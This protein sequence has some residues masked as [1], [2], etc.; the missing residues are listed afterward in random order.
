[1]ARNTIQTWQKI[2]NSSLQL[3][4]WLRTK[5][6]KTCS[7]PTAHIAAKMAATAYSTARSSQAT[8]VF[9]LRRFPDLLEQL[10]GAEFLRQLVLR[11]ERGLHQRPGVDLVHF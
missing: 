5:R 7:R 8:G 10:L 4:D 6:L 11:L 3:I 1:M 2:W 9:K